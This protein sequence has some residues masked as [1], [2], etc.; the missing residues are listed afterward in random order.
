MSKIKFNRDEIIAA[1]ESKGAKKPCHRCGHQSFALIDGFSRFH[2]SD[3]VNA[4]VL[5]GQGVP[6][7]LVACNNC[8]AITP[9]AAF[10]L[11]NP[12][13]VAEV[14]KEGEKDGE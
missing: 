13:D 4:S 14:K 9:H 5:G 7:V 10:A 2:L 1:L 8:G 11:M 6:S 12:E 3:E